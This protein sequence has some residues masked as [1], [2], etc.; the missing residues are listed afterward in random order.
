[1]TA[2]AP[3]LAGR[4]SA[5]PLV[6][7]MIGLFAAAANVLAALSPD[8]PPRA[9]LL[10]RAEPV[11]VPVPFHAGL[12]VGGSL[13]LVSL[14]LLKRRRRAAQV[15]VGLLALACCFDV[16]KAREL[17]GATFCLAFAA[18]LW[19]GRAAF[20][21][22]HEP[23]PRLLAVWR[24]A[25]PALAVFGAGALAVW[26]STGWDA[27]LRAV[28]RETGGLLLWSGGPLVLPADYRWLPF[29]L[30]ALGAAALIGIAGVLFRPLGLPHRSAE[31]RSRSAAFQLVRAHGHD[32]LAFFKLRWDNRLFFSVD[33][34]A[35]AA[36]KIA[37]PTLLISGD[38]VGPRE[39]IP[40]LLA[41]LRRFAEERGL[42]LGAVGAGAELLDVYR[43]NGLRALYIGDEA[44]VDT[45]A[46]SLDGRAIR[47]VR[48]SVNRITTAGFSTETHSLEELD[49]ATRAQLERI[50]RSWLAG[51]PE[52]GF[53]M[54]MDGLACPH[55][56]DTTV[57]VARDGS[58]VPRAF[59]HLVPTY[60][61]AAVS[62]SLMRREC[63]S[64][65]GLME[66]LIVNAIGELRARGVEELSLN[67]A[68]FARWMHEP[69]NR[70][71]RLLGRIVALGN[72]FF[73]IESLYRFNAKFAPRWS[74]RYLL[75]GRPL[76]LPRV[77]LATMRVEGQVPKVPRRSVP[78]AKPV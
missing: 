48:Q 73:Q 29:A 42:A 54:S 38:P 60:G 46:F 28:V 19:W 55:P 7:A 4:S 68:A 2:S 70:A 74:P 39:A 57:V 14:Y 17:E 11:L 49:P 33:G 65:N 12:A 50:S 63:D 34:K 53:A 40:G 43:A 67:F 76:D 1:M 25:A 27:G 22:R 5:I 13:A 3:S 52:R 16:V 72:P 69:A 10:L 41:E 78:V 45:N 24:L 20:C 36:Y 30:G 75:Y 37:G 26:A 18:L 58:G 9:G 23:V 59:L 64:P 47:K 32:T 8:I 61:R 56:A 44:I 66:F 62:L 51:A 15:A 35:F 21:V 31:E 71:E 77:A 6:A